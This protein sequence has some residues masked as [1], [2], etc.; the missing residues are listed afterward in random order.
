MKFQV[1]I[2][3]L[4]PIQDEISTLNDNGKFSSGTANI[5]LIPPKNLAIHVPKKT[6]KILNTKCAD[7]LRRE[8][9]ENMHK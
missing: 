2:Q 1:P 7:E 3:N 8:M 5:I 6:D 9:E 4:K